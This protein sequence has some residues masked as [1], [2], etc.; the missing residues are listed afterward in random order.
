[1]SEENDFYKELMQ[2]IDK[3]GNIKEISKP[4]WVAPNEEQYDKYY[5][6]LTQ[7]G[8]MVVMAKPLESKIFG[9]HFKGKKVIRRNILDDYIFWR[10]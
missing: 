2:S 6:L 8:F 10:L 5:D 9:K 7:S 4:V 1:M 3:L